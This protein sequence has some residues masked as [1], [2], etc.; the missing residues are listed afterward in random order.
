METSIPK[1]YLMLGDKLV[2]EHTLRCFQDLPNLKQVVVSTSDRYSAKT[3][4]ILAEVFPSIETYVVEG[5]K[6]RQNSISN[7]L[8]IID[9]SINMVMVHDAVRP[10]VTRE[11]IEDCI[12]GAKKTGG[13]ITG[14][15]VKDTIKE[16]DSNLEI[17]NTPD[18]GSLWQ[19]QTPQIFERKLL[20]KA[21][22]NSRINRFTVTDDASLIEKMGGRVVIV[23]GDRQNFKLTYP[24]DF[25]IAEMLMKN[26]E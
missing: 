15:R 4:E 20:L 11:L 18:R 8:Q 5:G 13:A 23:E 9:E 26:Q 1:P 6:E 16:V 3:E 24:L 7:A 12:N 2:L 21:Y 10:F 25:S 14:V 17:V 22:N 19:A